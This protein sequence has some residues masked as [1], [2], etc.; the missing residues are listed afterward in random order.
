MIGIE[1]V[2]VDEL[3]SFRR[4]AGVSSPR[5]VSP[6]GGVVLEVSGTDGTQR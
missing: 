4:S 5:A 2:A 6:L 3:D 1:M